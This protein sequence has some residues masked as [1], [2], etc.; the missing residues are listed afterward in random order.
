MALEIGHS[1]W[2]MLTII[3]ILKPAY[4]LTQQRNKDRLIGTIGGALV[5]IGIIYFLKNNVAL[6]I[7][8]IFF[9]AG[10]FAFLRRHYFTGVFF[11]TVYLLI[12]FHLMQ[13]TDFQELIKDRIIDTAIGSMISYIITISIVPEWERRTIRSYM[14][15]M[16]E[17]NLNYFDV[18]AAPFLERQDVTSGD[19][20]KARKNSLVSLANLSDAFNRMLSEPKS[21]QKGVDKVH[22][23]VV[24][25]HRLTSHLATLYHYH[26]L[27]L[28]LSEPVNIQPVVE[29]ARSHLKEAIQLF[30]K[31]ELQEKVMPGTDALKELYEEVNVLLEKRRQELRAGQLE[32]STKKTLSELKSIVDQFKFIYKITADVRKVSAVIEVS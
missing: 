23:F 21:Q 25:N 16:L 18:V 8:M 6:L 24:L 10:T 27:N 15:S 19:L 9:M 11:M 12:F 29:K 4:S 30:Q 17:D 22:Q 14:I 28:S 13:P 7:I 3:V 1:Y 32:T 26:E 2:I 5:G 31:E 20:R